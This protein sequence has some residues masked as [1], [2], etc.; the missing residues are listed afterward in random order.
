MELM[1]GMRTGKTIVR[2]VED[3]YLISDLHLASI[4]LNVVSGA[5]CLHAKNASEDGHPRFLFHIQGDPVKIKE[6]IDSVFTGKETVAEVH[7]FEKFVK[8]INYLKDLIDVS[9]TRE[10][11]K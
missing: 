4:V 5:E 11:S 1:K 2:P 10:Q 9:K 7:K 3:G 8:T 6:C